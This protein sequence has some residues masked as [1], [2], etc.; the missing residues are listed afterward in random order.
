MN[1]ICWIFHNGQQIYTIVRCVKDACSIGRSKAIFSLAVWSRTWFVRG[2]VSKG[3]DLGL[4]T[5]SCDVVEIAVIL[6]V[7]TASLSQ[8]CER[9]IKNK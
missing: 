1:Q 4:E 3:L 5:S 7:H 8:N 9:S 2:P 6:Q